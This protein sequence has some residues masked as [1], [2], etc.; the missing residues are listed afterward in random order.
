MA[1]IRIQQKKVAA[2]PLA[3]LLAVLLLLGFWSTQHIAGGRTGPIEALAATRPT[4]EAAWT[5]LEGRWLGL[6]ALEAN[7]KAWV[8]ADHPPVASFK[9]VEMVRV[10]ASR[11]WTLYANKTRG[12]PGLSSA[13]RP[14][15]RLYY[16]TRDDRFAPLRWRDVN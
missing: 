2:T 9:E 4:A 1:Q 14:Y 15:D 11:G 6:R 5:W 13:P 8:P 3:V 10:Q 16:H 12:L 7:G